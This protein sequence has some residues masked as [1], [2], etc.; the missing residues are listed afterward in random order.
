MPQY[1]L[2][3]DPEPEKI[4]VKLSSDLAAGWFGDRQAELL[5]ELELFAKTTNNILGAL[6]LTDDTS[7]EVAR[8]LLKRLAFLQSTTRYVNDIQISMSK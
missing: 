8:E 2:S 6:D 4:T 7:M 3:K 1:Q 5:N